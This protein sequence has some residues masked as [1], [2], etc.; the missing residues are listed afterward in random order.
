VAKDLWQAEKYDVAY[1]VNNTVKLFQDPTHDPTC[2]LWQ[3]FLT[4]GPGPRACG[5]ACRAE[6]SA[7]RSCNWTLLGGA[8]PGVRG[9]S[10]GPSESV[11]ASRPGA[12]A[13]WQRAGVPAC[14]RACV[15]ACVMCWFLSSGTLRYYDIIVL[16]WYHSFDFDIMIDIMSMIS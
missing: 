5:W 11:F 10:P 7:L 6:R 14:L 13:G 2:L 9:P 15:P 8:G 16:L 1:L 3:N 4:N 12:Q